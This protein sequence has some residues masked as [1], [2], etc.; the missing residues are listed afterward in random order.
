[1]EVI[2]WPA[3]EIFATIERVE[4]AAS[5]IADPLDRARALEIAGRNVP[6]LQQSIRHARAAAI[7]QA[8]ETR[9]AT[10][11]A[12][13]LGISRARLYQVLATDLG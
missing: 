5:T 3:T 10:V 1:M 4:Q 9:S 12:T 13:E 8:L 2:H 7:E 6:R 11:V